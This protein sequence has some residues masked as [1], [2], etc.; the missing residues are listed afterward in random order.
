LRKNILGFGPFD[1]RLE[2]GKYP[3][4]FEGIRN[5]EYRRL[6]FRERRSTSL[7]KQLSFL[8]HSWGEDIP[9]PR[10]VLCKSCFS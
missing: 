6:A 7:E 3:V 2:G 5:P 10:R 1:H 4:H 9:A 8:P